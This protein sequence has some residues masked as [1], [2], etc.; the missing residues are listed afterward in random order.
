[1]AETSPTLAEFLAWPETDPPCE[2]IDGVV[3]QKP[4]LF[5]R[6]QWVR[7]DLATLLYGW[8]RASRQ[9][10]V[11]AGVRCALGGNSYVPDV[12]YFSPTRL[13]ASESGAVPRVAPDFAIEVCPSEVDPAWVAAKV[14]HYVAHGVRLAWL[15][16]L[17][18]ETVTV[19]EPEKPPATLQRGGMLDGGDVL[20]G[21]YLY[22]DDLFDTLLEEEQES[23]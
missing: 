14:A 1:M 5:G 2:Y 7:A 17:G 11:S 15:V 12:V 3:V 10:A 13:P 18:E 4:A 8:A 19:Y 20:P 6:E 9:G 23:S 22:L 16:D 21:F